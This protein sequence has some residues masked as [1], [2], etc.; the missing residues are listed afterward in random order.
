M[1][2]EPEGFGDTVTLAYV[3]DTEVAHSFHTSLMHLLLADMAGEGRI[4][5]GG[6]IQMRCGTGG[7]IEARNSTV[8]AFLE[9]GADWLFWLDTDMGFTPDTLERLLA[10]ADPVE[11]P[12]VGA[13]CFAWRE[14]GPDGMGGVRCTP[15]PTLHDWVEVD[16]GQTFM[17]RR[18]YD[19]GE[20]TQVAGTGSACI[21]IHRTVLEKIQADHGPTWYDRI[22]LNDGKRLGEDIS[23]CV[24]AGA[25]GFPVHV[26]TGVRTTHLKHIWVAE[27]DYVSAFPEA[28]TPAGAPPA[29]NR[30]QRRQAARAATKA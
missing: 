30:A 24:R 5:R 16:G 21:L 11:R 6:Y 22:R 19:A 10:A 9:Q 4:M 7:L 13:L 18:E 26:H 20:L 1:T 27:A 8:A 25:A 28:V 17:A 3:H 29:T 2:D 12:I 23:F 14:D 15:R